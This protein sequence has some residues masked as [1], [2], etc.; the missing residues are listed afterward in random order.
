MRGITRGTLAALALATV[1]ATGEAQQATGPK[2]AYVNSQ[3]ILAAAPGRAE[4]EAQ[5]EKEMQTFRT[6]VQTMGDS[7][8]AMVAA[9]QKEEAALSPAVKEQRQKTIQTKE[10]EYQQRARQLEQQAAKRQQELVQPILDQI[11]DVLNTIREEG[12]YAMILDAQSG[13]NVIVAADKNLDLTERVIA[14][15]R[16]MK[17]ATATAPRPTGAPLNQTPAGVSRPR[18]P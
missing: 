17:P 13:A 14:R 7:L 9:Y 16:T 11:T 3:A 2:L 12:G 4:A 6:Q 18:N 10:A 5:F 8:N 15:L 1:A